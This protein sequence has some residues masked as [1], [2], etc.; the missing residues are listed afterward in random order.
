MPSFVVRNFAKH[1]NWK[2]HR[3]AVGSMVSQEYFVVFDI[4][5][6]M[7]THIRSDYIIV[8]LGATGASTFT[9]VT[10]DVTF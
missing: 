10:P 9:G 5:V 2:K 4:L 8:F 6:L 1:Q 3:N 7:Q